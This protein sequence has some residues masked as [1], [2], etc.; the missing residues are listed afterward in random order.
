MLDHL[1]RLVLALFIIVDV[2][3]TKDLDV[4]GEL[5]ECIN[6]GDRWRGGGPSR[7]LVRLPRRQPALG[8]VL[9]ERRSLF[10]LRCVSSAKHDLV[11]RQGAVCVDKA[12]AECK[13]VFGEEAPHSCKHV[14]AIG[15]ALIRVP[16]GRQYVVQCGCV[17]IIEPRVSMV[18]ALSVGICRSLSW[19]LPARKTLN[20]GRS[21]NLPTQPECLPYLSAIFQFCKRSLL[22]YHLSSISSYTI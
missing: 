3:Q 6:E 1:T 4:R 19:I 21:Y 10:G 18:W 16:E 22:V 17:A 8:V 20:S 11:V 2:V 9:Q 7:E 5:V 15:E 12:E 13:P 14:L